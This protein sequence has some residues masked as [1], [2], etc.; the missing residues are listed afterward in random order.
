[1]PDMV[2]TFPIGADKVEAWRRFCQELSGSRRQ[3]YIASRRRL[4]I[5]YERFALMETSFGAA[6]VTTLEAA[7]VGRALEQIVTSD[8]PFDRWYREKVMALHN[9]RFAG[10]ESATAPEQTSQDQELLFEWRLT[11]NTDAR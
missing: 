1:M 3:L 11:S 8:L 4:G 2:L 9:I 5:T 6:T 10:Y 7:D